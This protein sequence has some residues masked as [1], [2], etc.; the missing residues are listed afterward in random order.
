MVSD[1]QDL[2]RVFKGRSRPH[3]DARKEGTAA[4]LPAQASTLAVQP[5][6]STPP[7]AQYVVVCEDQTVSPYP[8]NVYYYV[9]AL[10]TDTEITVS[11]LTSNV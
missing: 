10:P 4:D 11:G 1:A 2:H 5:A 3:L 6:A 7:I 8:N 9:D